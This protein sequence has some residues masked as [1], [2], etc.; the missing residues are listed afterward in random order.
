MSRFLVTRGLWLIV[1]DLVITPIGWRFSLELLPAFAL[2][3]WALGISMIAMAGLIHLPRGLVTAG[4]LVM[5]ATHN[6]LD[7]VRPDQLGAFAPLWHRLKFP[8][9]RPSCT[10]CRRSASG[11]AS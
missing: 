6:L 11:P 5:I 8:P 9:P 7:G 4:S 3:L 10:G 1:L 2:V